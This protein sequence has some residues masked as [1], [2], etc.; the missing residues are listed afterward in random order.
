MPAHTQARL[1]G[2]LRD[3]DLLPD[4]QALAEVVP[5]LERVDADAVAVRDAGERVAP[6]H[7][8]LRA[9]AALKLAALAR[10]DG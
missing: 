9:Y 2:I 6:L 5:A 4:A 3:D 7:R 1:G 10:G 8:C